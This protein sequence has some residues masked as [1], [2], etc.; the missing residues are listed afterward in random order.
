[1]RSPAFL[2]AIGVVVTICLA[3]VVV[4][5]LLRTGDAQAVSDTTPLKAA[6]VALVGVGIA[7]MDSTS[8]LTTSG[9]IIDASVDV[10]G[11]PEAGNMSISVG[12][13]YLGLYHGSMYQ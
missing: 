9:N 2:F 4:I 12:S 5:T 10:S 1:L 13:A 11:N 8:G 6:V 3:L 7:Q